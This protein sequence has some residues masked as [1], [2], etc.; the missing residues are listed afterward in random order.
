MNNRIDKVFKD[1]LESHQ[2]SPSPAAWDKLERQLAKKNKAYVWLRAAAVLA[3]F[4]MATVVAINWPS[5]ST[6]ENEQAKQ[7]T[8]EPQ[9]NIP[10]Q[11][12]KS[13]Q[14]VTNDQATEQQ[15][16]EQPRVAETEKVAATPRRSD[17]ARENKP[18]AEDQYENPPVQFD[19]VPELIA[20][21]TPVIEQTPV[22]PETIQSQ[23]TKPVVIVYT[24]PAIPRKDAT[25][26]EE[27]KKKGF[28]RVLEVA[29]NVKN[30]DSPFGELREAK[31]DLFAL[32]FRRDKDKNKNNN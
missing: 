13:D 28:Q 25:Q 17:P 27:E 19:D 11:D 9:Q 6:P 8:A 22:A 12:P 3:L 14:P 30:A 7:E 10:V 23:E 20:D 1:K 29:N 31:N 5:A 24:L 4:S 2:L 32:E 18:A 16:V 15:P 21:A 26:L